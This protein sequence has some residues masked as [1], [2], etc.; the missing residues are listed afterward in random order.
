MVY[1]FF[2]WGLLGIVLIVMALIH[3]VRR[4]P[5]AYWLYL[6]IFLGPLG[7][8]IYLT[9]EWLPELSDPGAF[10]SLERGRRLRE[11]EASV[12]QNPSAGNYEELGL[13][14]LDKGDWAG[15]RFCFDKAIA[16]RTDSLDPFY[17]RGLAE[18]ELGDFAAARVDL[19][20]VVTAEPSYD[21]QRAAGLLA[22]ADWKTGDIERASRLFEHVLRTSTLTETQLNYAE[23]LAETGHRD[24][25]RQQALR[26]RDKRAGMPGFQR[27]QER[28]LFRRNSALLRRL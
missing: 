7:A 9:V 3:Y 2:S 11:V 4:Q 6:I 18:V 12:R 20:R 17:R 8:L 23:F 5:S 15:A 10:R 25:A 1:R 13:L 26:I 16:Q 14:R 27:R 22:Y 28:K 24:E 19:E 21:L